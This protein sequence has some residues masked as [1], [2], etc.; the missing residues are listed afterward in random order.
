MQPLFAHGNSRTLHRLKTLRQ[1]A[2]TDKAPR[3]A[4]RLQAIMLSVQQQT[5]GQIAQGLQVDRT[6]VHAWIGAWNE[7]G[8]EGLLEGHRSGR[9]AQLSATQRE[10]LADILDSGP[11]AYGLNTG[12]WTSPLLAQIIKEEF[13]VSYH[14]GHV[15][16]LLKQLNFSVQRPKTRL[17]QADPKKQNR[18]IRYTH[19][20]LKK[21]PGAKGR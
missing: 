8:A 17:V 13:A 15:R 16:H 14:P 19:P 2:Q 10:Q 12:V 3:V 5:T 11:V 18:W 6:R 9:P 4:L 20:N 21:T 7:Y 1:A